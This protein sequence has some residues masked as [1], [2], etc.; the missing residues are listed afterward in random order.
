MTGRPFLP[1]LMETL[2][3]LVT[4]PMKRARIEEDIRRKSKRKPQNVAISVVK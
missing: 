4:S 2:D 3:Q 1:V